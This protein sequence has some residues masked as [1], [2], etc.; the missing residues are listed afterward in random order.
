MFG[1]KRPDRPPIVALVIDAIFPYHLGGR[2]VRYHELT[3]RLSA[4]VAIHVYTMHWWRGSR[5]IIDGNVTFHA[6]SRLHPMY[7]RG[8]RSIRQAVFFALACL[9]LLGHRFDVLDAD[10]S[11]SGADRRYQERL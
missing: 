9:R 5:T 3:K 8:Q 1:C 10:H 4:R 2:E 7:A 6:I 11:D